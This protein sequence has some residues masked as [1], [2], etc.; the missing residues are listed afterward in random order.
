M[1][2][3]VVDFFLFFVG[4]TDVSFADFLKSLFGFLDIVRILVR[5]PLEGQL[6]VRL[7]DL[8]FFR[9]LDDAQDFIIALLRCLHFHGQ[10]Y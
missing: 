1:A 8:S 9:R 5:M 7:P 6:L 4:E 2:I 3:A 10:L